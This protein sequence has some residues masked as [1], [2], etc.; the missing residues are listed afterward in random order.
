MGIEFFVVIFNCCMR[1]IFEISVNKLMVIDGKV[2]MY[3]WEIGE[4]GWVEFRIKI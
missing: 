4:S 1:E 2:L 3:G